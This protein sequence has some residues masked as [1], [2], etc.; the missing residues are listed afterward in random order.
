MILKILK[1]MNLKMI[2]LSLIYSNAPYRKLMVIWG[3]VALFLSVTGIRTIYKYEN[4]YV[5]VM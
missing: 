4:T 1:L 5:K 2:R 3:L